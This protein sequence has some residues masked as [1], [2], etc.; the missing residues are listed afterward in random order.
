M[1]SRPTTHRVLNTGEQTEMRGPML[2]WFGRK[3]FAFLDRF[4]FN[5]PNAGLEVLR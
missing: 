5:I 3:Y 1:E 2:P 4:A